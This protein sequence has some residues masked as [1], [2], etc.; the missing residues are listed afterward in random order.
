MHWDGYTVFSVLSGVTLIGVALKSNVAAKQRFWAFATGIVFAGYGFFVAS[1]TSGLWLF[2]IWIFVLPI[3]GVIILIAELSEA[4]NKTSSTIQRQDATTRVQHADIPQVRV[5]AVTTGQGADSVFT[6]GGT[7][8]L[9]PVVVSANCPH[10]G[11]PVEPEFAKHGDYRTLVAAAPSAPEKAD[12]VAAPHDV[13]D[14]RGGEGAARFGPM[15]RLLSDPELAAE[16]RELKRIYGPDLCAI[17]LTDKA[18][19]LG[20]GE[21]EFTKADIPSDL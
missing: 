9:P 1:Q 7:T 17:F 19:E 11:G 20:L 2:P 8:A 16:A 5:A 3:L 15:Q 10:C 12:N 13:T 18:L 21:I 6:A 14:T 4:R